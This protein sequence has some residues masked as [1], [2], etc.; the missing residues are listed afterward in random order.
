MPST[1]ATRALTL[2]G[3]GCLF[4]AGLLFLVLAVLIALRPRLE[5]RRYRRIYGEVGDL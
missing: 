1:E 5:A 3:D 4:G 2:I